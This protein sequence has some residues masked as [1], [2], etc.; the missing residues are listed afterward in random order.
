MTGGVAWALIQARKQTLSL[1]AEI[2]QSAA[3]SQ[4]FAGEHHASWIVGHLLLADTY[5]LHL[6]GLE[7]LD[8]D[9]STLLN[10]YGPGAIPTPGPG[11]YD[12]LATLIA[13]LTESGEE[14][15]V[16]ISRLTPADLARP[17]PDEILAQVQPTIAHHL[18]TLVYHE[19]YHAGQ[20]AAWRRN[21]HLPPASWTFAPPAV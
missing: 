4:S 13:R 14:R 15:I 10:C 12:P 3:C 8:R 20:L 19:G 17:L 9:F 18:I 16:A 1:V 21:H 6:L 5:L 7:P 2:P 11:P